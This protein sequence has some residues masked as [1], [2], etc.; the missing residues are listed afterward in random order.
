MAT[1][2]FAG[3]HGVALAVVVAT[4]VLCAGNIL[5]WVLMRRRP[6]TAELLGPVFFAGSLL[7]T[8]LAAGLIVFRAMEG[9]VPW[10]LWTVV[11]A[12]GGGI[13][14]WVPQLREAVAGAGPRLGERFR[15]RP[16]LGLLCG[17]VWAL[18]FLVC[19]AP[20]T[21]WDAHTL[22]YGILAQFRQTGSL[23][24]QGRTTF[25]L[26]H[27]NSE[28]LNA[29]WFGL[30]GERAANLYYW[31]QCGSLAATVYL[32]VGR[33]ASREWGVLAGLL[34]LWL[35]VTVHQ[36]AGGWVDTLLVQG[37]LLAILTYE[38]TRGDARWGGAVLAG[39]FGGFTWGVK[40]SAPALLAPLVLMAL[41]ELFAKPES[42]RPAV[43]LGCSLALSA[44][45][46]VLRTWQATGNPFFPA[47][48]PWTFPEASLDISDGTGH[49]A[50]LPLGPL[51]MLMV[52]CGNPRRWLDDGMPIWIPLLIAAGLFAV[53]LRPRLPQPRRWWG[54]SA[55]GFVITY[56]VF[57]GNP[58]Y[59]VYA[60]VLALVPACIS[61]AQAWGTRRT[62]AL[63][64]AGITVAGWALAVAIAGGKAW[65][66]REVLLGRVSTR[67]FLAQTYPHLRLLD[68]VR[69]QFRPGD[70]LMGFNALQ[71][72]GGLTTYDADPRAASLRVR[73]WSTHSPEQIRTNLQ[74]LHVRWLLVPFG[75]GRL[76]AGV[77]LWASRRLEQPSASRTEVITLL[78][79]EFPEWRSGIGVDY[80][81][82]PTMDRF[83]TVVD[84]LASLRPWL[85]PMGSAPNWELYRVERVPDWRRGTQP[86]PA[87]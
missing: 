34:V 47:P 31:M 73:N 69:D 43:L 76:S 63:G 72:H 78:G 13:T 77:G 58:R 80:W 33:A 57:F 24:V 35:P 15:A 79:S 60:Y 59:G 39:L 66:R 67:A 44:A 87:R 5:W 75:Y 8:P 27:L 4:V 45:P 12:V 51:Q 55:L 46:W 82:D 40:Q 42:R 64:V 17:V 22:H 56:A 71:Y 11:C 25:D 68:D 3:L 28:V 29:F 85:T 62:A 36:S 20:N 32:A 41:W 18:E 49:R 14:L 26:Y 53:V 1:L 16:W 48:S 37:T 50:P 86:G 6:G 52:H 10:A 38:T 19:L 54:I 84:R 81:P 7:L 61:G 21:A 9:W 70:A 30:G 74:E 23:A 83:A 65:N 2:T